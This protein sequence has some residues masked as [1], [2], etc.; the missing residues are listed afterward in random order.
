[1]SALVAITELIDDQQGNSEV[2]AA[3]TEFS[4]K[5]GAA[6]GVEE[7]PPYTVPDQRA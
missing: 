4:S 2:A 1:L 5:N 7:K 6:V 3:V